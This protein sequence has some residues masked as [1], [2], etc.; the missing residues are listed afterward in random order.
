MKKWVGIGVAVYL[1]L[2]AGGFWAAPPPDP[3][4]DRRIALN[5]SAEE[6]HRDA[7]E[8]SRL[9]DRVAE[10]APGVSRAADQLITEMS[11]MMSDTEVPVPEECR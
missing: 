3:Q 8:A 4:C 7:A 11:V 2:M 10:D 6:W 9:T 5:E 1:V